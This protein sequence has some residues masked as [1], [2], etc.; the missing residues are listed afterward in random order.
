MPQL[1]HLNSLISS[2]SSL[3]DNQMWQILQ[4]F[5]LGISHIV[6][7]IDIPASPGAMVNLTAFLLMGIG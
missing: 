5:H 2:P 4:N 7:S 1:L 3:K 6:I